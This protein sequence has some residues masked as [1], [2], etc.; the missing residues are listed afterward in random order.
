MPSG[1]SV[2][3]YKVPVV[4]S[5]PMAASFC[6]SSGPVS[7]PSS[8]QNQEMPVFVSPLISVQLIALPPRYLGNNDG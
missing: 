8:T 1:K 5:G 7:M 3:K 4:S 6:T 2:S